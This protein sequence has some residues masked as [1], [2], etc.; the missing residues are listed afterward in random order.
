MEVGN[1]KVVKESWKLGDKEI[2]KCE[3]YKYLGEIINR[4]GKNDE[5]LKEKRRNTV[6][7]S[8]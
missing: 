3:N 5:N 2:G 1:H 7:H 6:K 4:N 8:V